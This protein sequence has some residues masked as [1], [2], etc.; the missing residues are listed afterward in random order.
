MLKQLAICLALLMSASAARASLVIDV[1]DISLL[2]G[3][4]GQKVPIS[5]RGGDNVIQVQFK[6]QID[7]GG[8]GVAGQQITGPSITSVDLVTGTIF[9]TNHK[10]QEPDLYDCV[11]VPQLANAGIITQHDAV[12]GAG[13]LATITIDTTHCEI[14]SRYRLS[15]T[16]TIIAGAP[17]TQFNNGDVAADITNGWI[18]IGSEVPE[19]ATGL[20]VLGGA[21]LLLRRRR[22][23]AAIRSWGS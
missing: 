23:G 19:P 22:R 3:T 11:I 17:D 2:P 15:L 5:V 9:E 20:L 7:D 8:I 4:P 1:G 14:G 13:L 16:G 6:V 21:G 18:I 10:A 12:G